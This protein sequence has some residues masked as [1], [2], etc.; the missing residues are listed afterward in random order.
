MNGLSTAI[1]RELRLIRRRPALI[2]LTV[3][4]PLALCVLLAFVFRSGVATN[5]PVAVVDLDRSSLSRQVVRMLDATPDVEV[6]ARADS[7][8]E[9]RSLIL[10]GRARGALLLPA[11]FERDALRG[12]RPEAV[13]FYDN[14]HM[15]AGSVI[16]RGAR[17]AVTAASGAS[18]SACAKPVGPVRCRP[19]RRPSPCRCRRMPFSTPPST[20]STSCWRR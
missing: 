14:Q 16:A 6:S 1:Q 15:S 5:L 8:P 17:N 10:S 11:G 2:G 13:I 18:A 20:M 9:A 19:R 12:A 4:L 7:L 3:V